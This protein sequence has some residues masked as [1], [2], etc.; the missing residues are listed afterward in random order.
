MIVYTNFY[1][2]I[3]LIVFNLFLSFAV[4][5]VIIT[6][7]LMISNIVKFLFPK[8]KDSKLIEFQNIQ[9]NIKAMNR[10]EKKEWLKVEVENVNVDG[11]QKRKSFLKV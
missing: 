3:F 9:K 5:Y 6:I 2:Q 11:I 7:H 10:P 4:C 1:T 8:K